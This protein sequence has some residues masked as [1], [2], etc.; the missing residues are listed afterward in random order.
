MTIKLLIIDTRVKNYEVFINSRQDGV[1]FVTY[2]YY[3]DTY[4][5][6]I[7]RILAELNGEFID[8]VALISHASIDGYFKFLGTEQPSIL[9]NI[10]SI[11]PSLNSW[12][13][14]ASFWQNIG[15]STIDLLGCALYMN[16]D[17]RY[18]LNTLEEQM[19]VD[20]RASVDDT[21][22]LALGGNWIL[23]SDN[24]N[25]KDIYFTE[26]IEGWID[27]LTTS[28]AF[29]NAVIDT[30]GRLY[31][32]GANSDGQ[33]GHGDIGV[34]LTRFTLVSTISNEV[35]IQV[36]IGGNAFNASTA[37]VTESGKLYVWGDNTSG[38]LGLG[39]SISYSTPQLVTDLSSRKIVSVKCTE[40]NLV[41]LDASGYV[42][43]AGNQLYGNRFLTPIPANRFGRVTAGNIS[44]EFIVQIDTNRNTF[45][46]LASS[47]N[48]YMWGTQADGIM[49]N[50]DTTTI[51][52][53]V[54]PDAVLVSSNAK[55]VVI[56]GY[57]GQ[58]PHSG[59]IT[60]DDKLI[61]MGS[62]SNYQIRSLS[63][64]S[65]NTTNR[66]TYYYDNSG[67]VFG[68]DISEVVLGYRNTYIIKKNG[69]TYFSGFNPFGWGGF[70]T[71]NTTNPIS[72]PTLLNI[73][74]IS[75]SSRITGG[76]TSNDIFTTYIDSSNNLRVVGDNAQGVLG[77]GN[78]TDVNTFQ[79]VSGVLLTP[80]GSLIYGPKFAKLADWDP[81]PRNIVPR[82]SSELF[83][84]FSSA[85]SNPSTNRYSTYVNQS[86]FNI[87]SYVTPSAYLYELS[88][89]LDSTVYR[90]DFSASYIPV[91]PNQSSTLTT[92]EYSNGG[93]DYTFTDISSS[94]NVVVAP[95]PTP[96]VD[97]PIQNPDL[98][99]EFVLA[100]RVID[101]SSGA[102]IDGQIEPF[103]T[104]ITL[105][106]AVYASNREY[107]FY[108][109]DTST[110]AVTLIGQSY[111][112]GNTFNINITKNNMIVGTSIIPTWRFTTIA[113][114]FVFDLS[115]QS[116]GVFGEEVEVT[117]TSFNLTLDMSAS[118]FR[119]SLLYRD[120][121]A[122]GNIDISFVPIAGNLEYEINRLNTLEVDAYSLTLSDVTDSSNANYTQFSHSGNNIPPTNGS[123]NQHFV[124]YIAS[125]M[126]GHPQAQA[127]IKNDYNIMVDLCNNNLGL[128]FITEMQDASDIRHSM[129]EQLIASDVSGDRFD[130]S[131]NDGYYPYPFLQGDKIVFTVTMQGNLY[132]DSP[133]TMSGV[134]T[135]TLDLL[136]RL[137][138][139]IPGIVLNPFPQ[140]E[141]R[142]WK[143]T[144]TL[145]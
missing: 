54:T 43:T 33:L 55:K 19:D 128:K 105:D 38:K 108:H 83:E 10:Q 113:L 106:P 138:S 116:I 63:D 68:T 45:A 81:I 25:A 94:Y 82:N 59:F 57:P 18:V 24:V 20:F 72:T 3:V 135:T 110:N 1:K 132:V 109:V 17:W 2:D 70:G 22:A 117:D 80:C 66:T 40:A 31:T 97:L 47:N 6:L 126:F 16:D 67:A 96:F 9:Q 15:A 104:T 28:I 64:G 58:G 111:I 140:F 35:I 103:Q 78:T 131:D 21:G 75:L 123:L 142:T 73:N 119:Q 53:A 84:A 89:I 92:N 130:I 4:S 37:C 107:F 85:F 11:D 95:L 32:C 61:V 143:I 50:E 87:D 49:G 129:L 41:C 127:P 42:Y 27:L 144:I 34:R 120:S 122:S 145:V 69:Q 125:L 74:A 60:T 99:T 36:A 65:G 137:F 91:Q 5:S 26:A 101:A 121:D 51:G 100:Y 7:H 102:F 23:E 56:G 86:V 13:E 98:R 90:S 52:S 14:F 71:T 139:G 88:K 62:N 39:N 8:T 114:P 12:T 44:K 141:R 118:I 93:F 46:A 30:S 77:T 115:A 29:H 79:E 48:L 136:T 134:S 112:S 124:Q 76:F 133:T